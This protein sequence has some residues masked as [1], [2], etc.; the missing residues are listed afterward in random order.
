MKGS[1]ALQVDCGMSELLCIQKKPLR[2]TAEW[3]TILK[4]LS[5]SQCVCDV[6]VC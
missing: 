4:E 1:G 2:E 3:F 5:V 6:P